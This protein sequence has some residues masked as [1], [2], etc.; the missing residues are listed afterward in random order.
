MAFEDKTLQCSEC[1]EIFVFSANEQEFFSQKNLTSEPKRCKACR[2]KAKKRKRTQNQFAGEYRSPAFND[3]QFRRTGPRRNGAHGRQQQRSEYRSPSFRGEKNS[4]AG[5]YRSPAF[6]EYE[7]MDNAE[8]YRSPAFRE[9]DHIKPEEEYRSPAFREYDHIKPEEEYRSPAFS[10]REKVRVDQRPLFSIVCVACG[11]NA[12]V[13]FLPEEKD[14][15]MCRDCYREHRELLRK[16]KEEE[17]RKAAAAAKAENADSAS[18]EFST[19]SQAGAPAAD[20][21]ATRI[22]ADTE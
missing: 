20:E 10:S 11:Q 16:E 17:A 12:M 1:N 9:Y 15:P 14:D 18:S 19:E 7:S 5:E 8:D 2:Q 3:P 22:S 6:R 4:F 21:S 13:P